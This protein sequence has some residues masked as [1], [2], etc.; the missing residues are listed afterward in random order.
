MLRTLIL[1]LVT[2]LVATVGAAGQLLDRSVVP[3]GHIRLQVHP[4]YT[5]WD[6]RFGRDDSGTNR[7]ETL[8]EDLTRTSA[9]DLFSGTA[10][11]TGHVRNLLA[12]PGYTPRFGSVQSEVG[13][14]VSSIDFGGDIGVFDWLTVGLVVPW[15]RTRTVLDHYF[16]PHPDGMT[17]GINPAIENGAAVDAFLGSIASAVSSTEAFVSSLCGGGETSGCVAARSLRD[18]T[19]AFDSAL[20]GAYAASAFFPLAGSETAFALQAAVAALSSD[21][22]AAGLGGLTVGLVFSGSPITEEDF[23]G[24][25]SRSGFGIQSSPLGTQPGLW[26]AG[27]TEVSVL[28]RV[29]NGSTQGFVGSVPLDYE[30]TVGALVRLGTG[31]PLNPDI[32]FDR[33]SGDGQT[34]YEGSLIVRLGLGSTFRLAAG[35]RYGIQGA[36]TVIRRVA[37]HEQVLAPLASRTTLEW[38][39]GPYVGVDVRPSLLL[40][41]AVELS[42]IY[43]FFQKNRDEFELVEAASSLDPVV[44]AVETGIKAH[45]VG[46][47]LRYDGV[48]P[49]LAGAGSF[50]AELHLRILRTRAGSGGQTPV[51]TRAEAGVR[52]FRRLWGRTDGVGDG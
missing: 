19:L 37:P 3:R 26:Q 46:A 12:D 38:R 23:A 13:Y 33:G 48:L 49:W 36:A 43:R 6:A 52:V 39:P 16:E 18:R 11:L 24:L 30:A 14:D 32:L 7:E 28:A 5:S 25:S 22:V 40:G 10:D 29:L 27:D 44:L 2:T 1:T 21:L 4:R 47:G 51:A 41:G 8:G 9:L 34:D 45:Q 42:G 35:A 20:R 31:T 50:P 17:V 15:S